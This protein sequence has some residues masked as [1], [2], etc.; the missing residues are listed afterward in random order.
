MFPCEL[1]ERAAQHTLSIRFRAAAQDLP[2]HLGRIYGSVM[3]HLETLGEQDTG[4]AYAAFHN[5]DMQNLDMEA[6]FPV[7]RS[8]PG[9]DDIQAGQIPAGMFAVCHYTGPYDQVGPAYEQLMQFIMERGYT[10][11]GPAYE[12]YFDGPDVPPQD[13]RTDIVFPVMRVE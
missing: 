8:L 1:Q 7:S 2:A 12:W 10:V 6:G 5:M 13:S 11:A 3:Q 4:A 9:K